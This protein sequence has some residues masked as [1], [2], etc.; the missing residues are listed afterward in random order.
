MIVYI[1]TPRT[2]SI[3]VLHCMTTCR[4]IRIWCKKELWGFIRR[5][6]NIIFCNPICLPVFFS[7]PYYYLYLF[8]ACTYIDSCTVNNGNISRTAQCHKMQIL[9]EVFVYTAVEFCAFKYYIQV[10]HVHI[11]SRMLTCYNCIVTLYIAPYCHTV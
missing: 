2:N 5:Y 10:L 6:S 4:S 9:C 1:C 8:F 11:T 3:K 7:N